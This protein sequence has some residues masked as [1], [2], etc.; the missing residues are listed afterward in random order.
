MSKVKQEKGDDKSDQKNMID[1]NINDSINS[2]SDLKR[3]LTFLLSKEM[4][5]YS[6]EKR[7]EFLLKKLSPSVV[8]KAIDLYQT[9]EINMKNNID[10]I[11]KKNKQQSSKNGAFWSSLFDLGILSTVLL[12]SLGINYLIDLNRN[13]KNE[14][15]FREVEKKRRRQ[16]KEADSICR[17]RTGAQRRINEN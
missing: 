15:F 1:T 2:D 9:I 8:E 14:M 7:K 12:T 11:L 13:K 10:E 17:V 16:R 4:K 6:L 5:E 3:A